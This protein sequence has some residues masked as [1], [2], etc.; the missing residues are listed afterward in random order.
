MFWRGQ[1]LR[2]KREKTPPKRGL[3]SV[4]DELWGS[5][6]SDDT[7][8]GQH[9]DDAQNGGDLFTGKR[10]EGGDQGHEGLGG[11]HEP[12]GVDVLHG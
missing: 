2:P 6:L 9:G 3:V 8:T 4:R 7:L 10:E 11:C 5:D 12:G 1:K